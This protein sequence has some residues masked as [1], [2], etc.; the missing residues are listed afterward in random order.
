MFI[1][2]KANQALHDLQQM[3]QDADQ[4]SV[5]KFDFHSNLETN[6]FNKGFSVS[7]N[8]GQGDCMF[9]ALSEQ[10]YFAKGIQ[11]SAAELRQEIVQYL[12][13]NPQLVNKLC[14][15]Y[16]EMKFTLQA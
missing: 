8:P 4:R 16:F 9:Y 11:L 6:A 13:Q 2:F 14:S 7:D 15:C 10:L 3:H 5:K 12:Q 1:F